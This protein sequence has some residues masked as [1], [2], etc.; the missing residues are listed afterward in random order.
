MKTPITNNIIEK[1]GIDPNSPLASSIRNLEKATIRQITKSSQ[2]KSAL[3][4]IEVELK[5]A[6]SNQKFMQIAKPARTCL[7]IIKNFK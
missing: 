3:A 5:P 1:H 7:N 6:A 4:R 2:I